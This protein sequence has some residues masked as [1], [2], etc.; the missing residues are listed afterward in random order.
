M[1]F[2]YWM[3][4]LLRC[5]SANFT[6]DFR[7]PAVKIGCETCG[8]KLHALCDPLK[9]VDNWVLCPPNNPLGLICGKYAAFAT[10]MFALA[11]TRFC[12]AANMSGR[13]WSNSDGNP[14]GTSGGNSC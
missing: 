5:A 14:G 9:R 7:R 13:L 1:V 6:P 11:D 12:S 3:S 2:S 10:P 4:A 8:T